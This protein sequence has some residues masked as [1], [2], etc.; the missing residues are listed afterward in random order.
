M[1]SLESKD[2]K[3]ETLAYGWRYMWPI[4]HEELW[5]LNLMNSTKFEIFPEYL[6]N[7]WDNLTTSDYQ[8]KSGMVDDET[9]DLRD[10][11]TSLIRI[12][13]MIQ[14]DVLKSCHGIVYQYVEVESK[15]KFEPHI[16]Y[17]D[18]GK[19]YCVRIK[20]LTVLWDKV[21]V[22][23]SESKL[24]L[25]YLLRNICRKLFPN[26]S[27][28]LQSLR[29]MYNAFKHANT[30]NQSHK[31]LA[32]MLVS[33]LCLIHPELDQYGVMVKAPIRTHCLVPEI[34]DIFCAYRSDVKIRD[35]PDLDV[36]QLRWMIVPLLV[37]NG[38]KIMIANLISKFNINDILF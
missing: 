34:P 10:V 9:Q 24:L 31:S 12:N 21:R 3:A 13:E 26:C 19:L 7:Y 22:Q 35:L 38:E 37:S 29:K 15:R 20:N 2:I 28:A 6:K 32:L 5:E 16:F 11:K 27:M 8:P 4:W 17:E 36:T 1:S 33:L 30:N 18:Y 23:S 25:S 14:Q